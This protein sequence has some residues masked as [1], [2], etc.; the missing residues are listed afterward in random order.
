MS[1]SPSKTPQRDL[2][3]PGTPARKRHVQTTNAWAQEQAMQGEDNVGTENVWYLAQLRDAST[4]ETSGDNGNISFSGSH[5]QKSKDSATSRNEKGFQ[6]TLV[7]EK[8]SWAQ[9][10]GD[11]ND[12]GGPLQEHHHGQDTNIVSVPGEALYNG[13]EEMGFAIMMPKIR[14]AAGTLFPINKESKN[15]SVT[16][17]TS[18]K[19]FSITRKMS[20]KGIR[21]VLTGS[22]AGSDDSLAGNAPENAPPVPSLKI[23]KASRVLGL[24]V[25]HDWQGG[26]FLQPPTSAPGLGFSNSHRDPTFDQGFANAF[27]RKANSTPALTKNTKPSSPT[28]C[29]SSS[30][31]PSK[32]EVESEGIVLGHGNLSPTKSGSYGTVGRLEVVG[33]SFARIASQQGIIETM[34]DEAGDKNQGTQSPTGHSSA[35]VYS[36][37][38]YEGVWEHNPNVGRSLPPFSPGG[39]HPAQEYRQLVDGNLEA[40][41][42]ETSSLGEISGI[43]T[44]RVPRFS[45]LTLSSI[46]SM[47]SSVRTSLSTCDSAAVQPLFADEA[48]KTPVAADTRD[49]TLSGTNAVPPPPD[50]Y[51]DYQASSVVEF[52]EAMQKLHHHLE[53]SVNRLY[54]LVETQSDRMHDELIRRCE[55]LEEK[56]QKNGKGASKHDLNG[57]K[58]EFDLLGHDLHVT[59]TTGTEMKKMMHTVLAKVAALDELVK[60]NACKCQSQRLADQEGASLPRQNPMFFNGHG[61]PNIISSPGYLHVPL[62]YNGNQ[63]AQFGNSNSYASFGMPQFHTEPSTNFA[64]RPREA[65]EEYYRAS[66]NPQMMRAEV[67]EMEM[68]DDWPYFGKDQHCSIPLGIKGPNGV[69]YE[70]PSFMRATSKG[71]IIVDESPVSASSE[72][73]GG[74]TVND[75]ESPKELGPASTIPI[76]IDG[77]DDIKYDLPSFM[78]YDAQGNIVLDQ[79]DDDTCSP[80]VCGVPDGIEGPIQAMGELPS[81]TSINENGEAETEDE[82]GATGGFSMVA[83]A[84]DAVPTGIRMP[85]D[86]V[87]ELPSFLRLNE[88]GEAEVMQDEDSGAQENDNAIP[89]SNPVPIGIRMDNRVVYQPPTFMRINEEGLAEVDI[90]DKASSNHRNDV[91]LS[92]GTVPIGIPGP[93]GD[94]YELPSFLRINED[95]L[96][97]VVQQ[98]Q[99]NLEQINAETTVTEGI[100][101]GIRMNNGIL[102]EIPSFMNISEDGLVEIDQYDRFGTE[103]TTVSALMANDYSVWNEGPEGIYFN[104]SATMED[105]FSSLIN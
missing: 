53:T 54:R 99:P 66:G 38:M 50:S 103:I 60:D 6:A 72:G 93:N 47:H 69:L 37:S 17:P 39:P 4:G 58:N 26:D 35:A 77:P 1:S 11:V 16:E 100:P 15:R 98:E 61:A 80:A 21:N 33:N 95:G 19:P 68:H 8:N 32:G 89:Q 24:Q 63:F 87:Y 86:I 83:P 67:P 5:L 76:G 64:P 70:M 84:I 45:A 78:S 22:K 34:G 12:V 57:L 36:P 104:E 73:E 30:R 96:E 43:A 62:Q 102:Y 90:Q 23:D 18:S 7:H 44:K 55:S 10:A 105:I 48:E 2:N 101:V 88:D 28:K 91:A 56:I 82:K 27:G 52:L 9:Q 41:G 13:G 97:E 40:G 79:F 31:R 65:S 59:A 81:F 42:S 74:V 51:Q 14:R 49:A 94:L 3:L 92:V 71:A 75:D 46:I 85:N 20:F 29:K 25:H